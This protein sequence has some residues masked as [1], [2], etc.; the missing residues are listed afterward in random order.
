MQA[1]VHYGAPG[2]DGLQVM[3]M[4]EQ[5]PQAGQVKV[6]LKAAGLNGLPDHGTFAST[7]VVP[8]ENVEPKPAYLT[9]EE[10]GVLPL[11]A[12]TAY[13]ALVTRAQVAKGQPY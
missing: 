2:W 9:W 7:V 4:E 10:A 13:R 6:R 12:L 5:R 1:I 11:A 3:E 8:A